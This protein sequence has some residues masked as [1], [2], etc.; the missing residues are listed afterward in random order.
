MREADSTLAVNVDS[1]AGDETVYSG[2]GDL[3]ID[4]NGDGVIDTRDFTAPLIRG[5]VNFGAGDNDFLISAGSVFGNIS[6]GNGD[7]ALTLTNTI[8]DDDDDE[9]TAPTTTV[10]G[11]ITNGPTGSLDISIGERTRLHL[12]G[13]EGDSETETENLAVNSLTLNGELLVVVDQEQLSADTPLLTVTDL[14]VGNAATITPR[15]TGLP[16]DPNEETTV[17]IIS[18]GNQVT[19]PS[20]ILNNDT[21]F[22]YDVALSDENATISA[23]FSLKSVAE[24]QL[25]QTEG[26]ALNAV[27]AH[28]RGNENL[29]AAITG[30]DNGDNFKAAYRQLL[31][32]YSDGTAQQ[33]SGLADMATG[34]VSQ[35]L[36]LINAGG[37]RGG[38]GWV[39]QFGDYRKQDADMNGA[40]VSG[41]SYAIALGYDL[42]VSAIDAL[43]LYLQMGFSAVNE[44]SAAT[45]EIKGDG[46]SYGAYLSDKIGPLQYELNAAYGF[47][48]LESDRLVNFAGLVDRMTASWDATSTAASARLAYPILQDAHL[49]RLEAGTDFFRLEHDDYSESET[50]GR[51][52]AMHV[53]GGEV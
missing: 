28:F 22:I 47:V 34:A 44:K 35:H 7:D 15:L 14:T 52:F 27:L 23:N 41:T 21:P 8:L 29:E 30:I 20:T 19:L 18:Y 4:R 42:P 38:D 49:L 50:V 53:K 39:Q 17:D 33:L 51:G 48:G 10:T 9:Y 31:P 43:G 1:N 2:G 13:Q 46:I 25:N 11:R 24:L 6:F 16:E 5:D 40:T 12:V 45:N 37:R 36:Q 26:A 32:H 3:D